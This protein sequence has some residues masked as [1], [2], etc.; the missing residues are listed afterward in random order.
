MCLINPVTSFVSFNDDAH[1]TRLSAV[2]SSR[3]YMAAL[4]LTHIN[5]TSRA[6]SGYPTTPA[7]SHCSTGLSLA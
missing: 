7:D 1:R 5:A 6:Y 2:R 3:T 4:S